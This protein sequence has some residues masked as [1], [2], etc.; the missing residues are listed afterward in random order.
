M[1]ETIMSSPNEKM[2]GLEI[3]EAIEEAKR[4]LH[5]P[6]PLCKQG[7][8]IDNDIPDFIAALAKGNMGEAMSII[9]AKSNLPAVC[10]RVCPHE[11][12]CEGHCVLAKKGQG[13]KVG[14]IERFIADFDYDM[15]L[16]QDKIP[17]KTRGKV[18]V[19]GSGPAG[20]TVAGDLA[21]QGFHV[22]VF[23]AESEPGGV[24]LYGI[25][26]FRLP[27]DVVRREIKRIE[28]L[29]VTFVTNCVAGQ[30]I[31]IDQLFEKDF[32]AIFIGTGTA[33]AKDLDIPGKNMVG[34]IQSSY[35]LRMIALY[36]SNQIEM[37]DLPLKKGDDVLVIGGGNVA[38]D[39]ARS[40]I[41]LGAKSVTVVY[42]RGQENMSALNAEYEEALADGVQFQFHCVPKEYLGS[43]NQVKALRV[44]TA[45]GDKSLPADKIYLAVGSRP[46]D[47]VVS[48]TQG[49]EVDERGYVIIRER[50]YGMTTRK[51][52]F[53]GGDV[54]HQPATVVLA[55]KEAQK[56]SASIASYVD[57]I[58]LLQL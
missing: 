14:Q 35:L 6:K 26:A 45:D 56:V 33:V 3:Q 13:I 32:D 42:H 25:P 38:M 7:C 53:A 50:P 22:S 18:A 58:H 49:I 12:Q 47:R 17:A 31:T 21:K 8:P 57:A 29:G 2:P 9:A 40:A 34:I 48:T 51:N 43:E 46:A 41:R 1:K 44:E 4:C 37:D 11:L 52:V 24:L 5:C 10:G 55:M 19:I 54:V 30:D 27:K 20:L 39:A 28:N 16:T 23:E 15:H 36:N